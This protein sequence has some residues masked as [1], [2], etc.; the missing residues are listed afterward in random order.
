MESFR[1]YCSGCKFDS[2]CPYDGITWKRVLHY[3]TLCVGNPPVNGVPSA[4][5]ANDAELRWCFA[6]T[7]N[8][9]L[10]NKRMASEMRQLN[11]HVMPEYCHIA[12]L[13]LVLDPFSIY[14]WTRSQP[15]S[16][17]VTYVMFIHINTRPW[18]AN[19]TRNSQNR[20]RLWKRVSNFVNGPCTAVGQGQL[21]DTGEHIDGHVS[22]M[23]QK[24]KSK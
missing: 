1:W 15:L 4:Q 20:Q 3:R 6:V 16:E 18:S 5:R 19:I 8:N 9:P 23:K 11:A 12:G 13:C 24:L 14:A 10:N 17:N 7:L 22:Y 2:M 21:L